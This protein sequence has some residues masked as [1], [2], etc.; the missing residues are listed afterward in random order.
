[1]Y[2]LVVS[3]CLALLVAGC[4]KGSS[5]S[6]TPPPQPAQS[7]GPFDTGRWS[8]AI[9]AAPLVVVGVDVP[10]LSAAPGLGG[11]WDQLASTPEGEQAETL[12]KIGETCHFQPARDLSSLVVAVYGE[13]DLIL[14]VRGQFDEPKIATCFEQIIAAM[15]AEVVR[16]SIHGHTVYRSSN[17]SENARVAV[18]VS[19]TLVVAPTD[20]QLSRALAPD[21]ARVADTEPLPPVFAGIAAD[22]A[23]W[24]GVRF[25]GDLDL[26]ETVPAM[27]GGALTAAP[28]AAFGSVDFDAAVTLELTLL[29]DDDAAASALVGFLESALPSVRAGFSSGLV[30]ALI[31]G[32]A[33]AVDGNAVR[34]TT[35]IS[36]EVFAE[37]V[38]GIVV[39]D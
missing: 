21:T 12:A 30:P 18:P 5:P 35:S 15:E 9:P 13:D 23:V 37:T 8:D 29:M 7:S 17:E 33:I 26:S 27:T 1:M 31:D 16:S 22:R 2:K 38:R 4:A 14:V 19:G 11:L 6:V 24:F 10:A 28:R 36:R 32:A 3:S 39:G 25:E 20:A 34:I